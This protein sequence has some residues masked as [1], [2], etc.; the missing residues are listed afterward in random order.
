MVCA[1]VMAAAPMAQAAEKSPYWQCVTF[2]RSITGM[3]IFGDAWT[4]WEKASGKY[5]KG[6]APQAGAV[7]VFQPTGKMRVGHVAVVSQVVTDRIIQIT[8][9]NWSPINGRRGQVEKDV[10]V[11]DVSDKGD[12]SKVKVWYGPINDLGTSVYPTY[13]FIYAAAQKGQDI[14]QSLTASIAETFSGD[15]SENSAPVPYAVMKANDAKVAEKKAIEKVDTRAIEAKLLAANLIDAPTIP[16]KKSDKPAAMK[17]KTV[18]KADASS[19]KA[20]A[21]KGDTKSAS[22]KLADK[23]TAKSSGKTSSDKTTDKAKTDKK[24]ASVKSAKADAK[25]AA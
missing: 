3:Q 22:K 2:A 4:W 11:V 5:D 13:G 14:G 21:K 19:K 20:D 1:G 9:A 25:K 7:L 12:W 6:Q 8:H 10:T 16:V 17:T 23:S 18:V 15:K 24:V